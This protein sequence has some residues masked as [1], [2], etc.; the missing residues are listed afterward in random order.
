M[1]VMPVMPVMPAMFAVDAQVADRGFDLSLRVD[2]GETVAVLGPNGA[3]KSTLLAVIAGLLRPDAGHAELDGRVLFDLGRRARSAWVPP[4]ARG[5]ALLAQDPLLFPHLTVLE[6][7]A[8]GPRSAGLPRSDAHHIARKWLSEVDSLDLARRTPAQLSGGQAQRIAVAR[9][10]AARPGL[11][12]L[13]EPMSALDISVAPAVRRMLRRVLASRTAII[14]TH[15][16]LDA[17][18]LADRVIVIDH[19]RIV[20]EGP[21]RDVL[22]RPRSTFTARLAA[23]NV[24]TGVRTR[25]GLRTAN[26]TD[27]ASDA[28]DRIAEGT[29]VA[30]SIRPHA[31][32]V[33]TT[34]P[35]RCGNVV[36]GVI[37]DLEPRGDLIRVRSEQISADVTPTL[38]ADLDLTV[39][40]DVWFLFS[41]ADVQIYPL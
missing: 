31:V 36:R 41:A 38:V 28:V 23:L 5:V 37:Q 39:D 24:M 18:T 33:S 10:L 12:L 30:G 13:D 29:P 8:F 17:L 27:V 1:P 21:T 14:V 2:E 6:N 35:V 25:A 15:D 19:G 3:G 34:E 4:H 22:E 7:V 20:E 16:I 26:G 11:L 32:R 40:L 9:A